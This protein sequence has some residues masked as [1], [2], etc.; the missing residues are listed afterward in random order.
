MKVGFD[1]KRLFNNYT[2]LG[3]YSRTLVKNLSE[4]KLDHQYHLYSPLARKNKDTSY[5]FN[6][7]NIHI[8]TAPYKLMGAYWRSCQLA[9]VLQKDKVDLYH[10]LSHELPIGIRRTNI[11][12]VVT[13]HD[14]I[15]KILPDTYPPIDRYIYEKKFKY[16]CEVADRVVAISECTKGDLIKFYNID[17]SKISVVYQSCSPVF[18]EETVADT[19]I[20]LSQYR[21]PSE[22]ILYVGSIAERKNIQILLRAYAFLP[23]SLRIPLVLVGDGKQYLESCKKLVRELKIDNSVYWVTDQRDTQHL[24]TIYRNAQCFVYP[25]LYEGFGI[26]IIEALL[27]KTPVVASSASCLPEAGGPDSLYFD[28]HN[29]K[30]LTEQLVNVLTNQALREKMISKGYDFAQKNFSAQATVQNLTS[31]YKALF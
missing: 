23:E 7:H 27:S 30:E 10:G 14:L 22:Y 5:F 6:K 9:S 15:F 13:M 3:N 29:V 28:P 12:S 8:H 20:V 19:R 24:Q 2:G 25:S 18:F 4:A 1:G 21:M 16:S 31:V 11:R 17:P 26:P